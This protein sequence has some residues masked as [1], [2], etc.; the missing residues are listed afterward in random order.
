[1]LRTVVVKGL[2]HYRSPTIN[3]VTGRLQP[4]LLAWQKRQPSPATDGLQRRRE[5]VRIMCE[6]V[7]RLIAQRCPRSSVGA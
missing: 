5:D 6:A 1:M 3:S 7:E 2:L 4:D